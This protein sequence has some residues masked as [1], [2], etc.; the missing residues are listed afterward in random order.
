MALIDKWPQN[1]EDFYDNKQWEA[2]NWSIGEPITKE[3]LQKMDDGIAIL[4][5]QVKA[6]LGEFSPESLDGAQLNASRLDKVQEW[7]TGSSSTDYSDTNIV[8]RLS[9]IDTLNSTQNNRLSSIESVNTT[10]STDISSLKTRA[11]NLEDRATTIETLNSTQN[12]RLDSIESK[13]TEQDV[14]LDGIDTLNT[15]QNTEIADLKTRATNIESV[16]T[17]QNTEISSLKTRATN[18]ESITDSHN[19]SIS[20]LTSIIGNGTTGYNDL[21]EAIIAITEIEGFNDL[22]AYREILNYILQEI[23]GDGE[24]LSNIDYNI[25]SRIDI[26]N[27]Q[28]NSTNGLLK[29]VQTLATGQSTLEQNLVA[30]DA[31]IPIEMYITTNSSAS[32]T[33]A[34]NAS[35]R[36]KSIFFI[37]I[38]QGTL[39]T[40]NLI[41]QTN[42]IQFN[43]I[44]IK[45]TYNG[46]GIK[47]KYAPNS[48]IS[49]YRN[50]SNAYV[51]NVPMAL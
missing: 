30:T 17:A 23:W 49:I 29:Q 10:Q 20:N 35:P 1:K 45:K 22:S 11:T 26:L 42:D 5:T 18:L 38:S 6:I 44:T 41:L 8:S 34:I 40:N 25:D 15:S 19:E 21:T 50:G 24:T 39:G 33:L 3:K 28:I 13:N 48:L 27:N 9:G 37:A 7:I 2:K 4:A 51:I 47:I 43:N 14:R 46:E 12:G 32:D 36:D 31:K 16:N